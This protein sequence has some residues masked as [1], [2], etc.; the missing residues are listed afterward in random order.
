MHGGNI[1]NFKAIKPEEL[2]VNFFDAINHQW[3]LITAGNDE[4]INTMTASWGGMGILW[5]KN[6]SYVFIRDSRYTLELVDNNDYYSL[7]FFGEKMR[8]EL[9][10]CGRNS[11]RNTDKISQTGLSPVFDAEA[12]YFEQAE[13]VIICKKLYKQKLDPGCFIEKNLIEKFYSDNDWHEFFVG[14]IV[15]VL[16]KV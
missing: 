8:K 11:G 12:P 5:N 2:N 4:K 13:L 7:S 15:Q 14:E 6:V 1:V 3:M 9:A 10:F 16:K